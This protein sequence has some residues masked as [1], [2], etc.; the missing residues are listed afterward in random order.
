MRKD[1]ISSLEGNPAPIWVV[2]GSKVPPWGPLWATEARALGE[3]SKSRKSRDS[4][5]QTDFYHVSVVFGAVWAIISIIRVYL[6]DL[7]YVFV[8]TEYPMTFSNDFRW[9][10]GP[11]PIQ[12]QMNRDLLNDSKYNRSAWDET[13][14]EKTNVG[15]S[16]WINQIS[17]CWER[18]VLEAH[19]KF[20]NDTEMLFSEWHCLPTRKLIGRGFF[21]G[22]RSSG[23]N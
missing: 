15:F 4:G 14:S 21:E 1:E 8:R 19:Q 22:L 9:I 2:C 5:F 10:T 23:K 17:I 20:W 16:S 11:N 7:R 3:T 6:T 18:K 12:R 13:V